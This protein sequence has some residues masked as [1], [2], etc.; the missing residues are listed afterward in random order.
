MLNKKSLSGIIATLL[1]LVVVIITVMTLGRWFQNY[2]SERFTTEE[3]K[4]QIDLELKIEDL[5]N[6][7]LYI[8][9]GKAANIH[10]LK[11]T[12]GVG[13]TKCSLDN[14]TNTSQRELI[15][16]IN[17]INLSICNLTQGRGFE[18]ILYTNKSKAEDTFINK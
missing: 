12:D 17:T 5:I 10:I 9:A 18:I 1:I 16:G 14:V 15:S 4:A 3:E 7:E 6:S 11:I 13:D 8:R 2:L